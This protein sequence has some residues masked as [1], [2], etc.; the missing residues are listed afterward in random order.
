MAE[1]CAK[2][3]GKCVYTVE[4]DAPE[5]PA[6]SEVTDDSA[7]PPLSIGATVCKFFYSK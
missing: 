3:C 5:V 2:T 6:E 1:K 4:T 7:D